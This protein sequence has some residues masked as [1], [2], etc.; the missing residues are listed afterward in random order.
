MAVAYVGISSDLGDSRALMDKLLVEIASL[1]TV[2]SGA[3]IYEAK[4]GEVHTAHTYASTVICIETSLLP[5]E[6]CDRL[7]L[8]ERTGHADGE[9]RSLDVG[10]LWYEGVVDLT[11]L[12]SGHTH[13]RERLAVLAPM[14]D[15]DPS[16]GDA[17]GVFSTSL[18]DLLGQQIMR[19]TGPLDIGEGRWLVG[20][21]DA[22]DLGTEIDGR[23]TFVSHPDWANSS[24]DTFGAYL[25]AISL[26][27]V[28]AQA[29]TMSPVG[30][31]HRF[32]HS[33]PSGAR[34]EATLII[35]RRTERSL[36]ATVVLT[37][38]GRGA[39]RTSINLVADIPELTH[40]PKPPVVPDMEAAKPLVILAR[41]M[42][43]EVGAS[44]RNWGP[45][46]DWARPDLVGEDDAVLRLWSPNIAVGRH[47]VYLSAAALL[48]PI[49]AAIWPATMNTMGVL[50]HGPP[51]ATPTIELTAR[52]A[53]LTDTDL[54]HL[55]EASIDHRTESSVSGTIRVWGATGGYRAIGHSQN[56]VR[57]RSP[58]RSV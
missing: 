32:I 22:I 57:H 25:A 34:G 50:P 23:R 46:E 18:P 8:L 20:L 33:V 1:G 3:P 12:S 37:V 17:E 52:F 19:L 40:A 14:I 26:E 49:D 31:S 54:Y 9:K 35:N 4:T 48:M 58:D 16:L 7:R 30:L 2:E 10:V 28:R 53:D 15:L 13:I 56:L 39:G 24:Q 36:D 55:V 42:G 5:G 38:D 45:L 51:I 43:V 41:E 6:L 29:P 21:H 44:A 47:D 27:V 11:G